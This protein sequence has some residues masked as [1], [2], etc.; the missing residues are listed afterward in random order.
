MRAIFLILAILL[1][2]TFVYAANET[3]SMQITSGKQWN[4]QT[5]TATH[6]VMLI[7]VTDKGDACGISVDGYITWIDVGKDKTINGVY[8]KVF[9][10]YPVHSYLQDNDACKVFIGG[11]K[12]TM[13]FIQ[14]AAPA[15]NVS[16]NI[17]ANETKAVENKT[18]NITTNVTAPKE[19]FKPIFVSLWEWARGFFKGLFK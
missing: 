12:V 8:I 11:G 9:E 1:F 19:E 5:K 10:A 2:A 17:T 16:Q 15:V 6:K 7:D 3:S 18:E 4:V 13:P 14:E